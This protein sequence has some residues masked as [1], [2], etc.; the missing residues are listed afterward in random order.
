MCGL[1]LHVLGMRNVCGG[2][3]RV[4]A[5]GDCTYPPRA[6]P[7][8]P[9]LQQAQRLGASPVQGQACPSCGATAPPA[10][11]LLGA[12]ELFTWVR[13]PFLCQAGL[14]YQPTHLD[15]AQKCV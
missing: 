11:R 8:W 10:G 12:L 1:C 13:P 9:G 4:W 2:G 3:G 15:C 6:A 14:A 5:L 7:S